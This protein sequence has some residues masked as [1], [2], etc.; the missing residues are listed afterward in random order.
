M[1]IYQNR[2]FERTNLFI[3]ALNNLE[4]Y[5]D[6]QVAIVKITKDILE[7]TGTTMEDTEG[8]IDFVRDIG[9]VEIAIL[10]KEF[11]DEETKVSMRSKRFVDV[12]EITLAFNGGGHKKAAG[13]TI[14]KSICKADKLI[15]NEIKKVF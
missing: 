12:S 11:D 6:N 4:M 7:A 1:N 8:I 3:K 10:M 5:F 9:P 2:S 14:N 13:C 15:L